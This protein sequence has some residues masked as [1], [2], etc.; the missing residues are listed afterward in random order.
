M[1]EKLLSKIENPWHRC[2]EIKQKRHD[3][4]LRVC[5][6]IK[7]SRVHRLGNSIVFR[8]VFLRVVSRTDI[9]FDAG[10]SFSVDFIQLTSLC[11]VIAFEK[12]F[13]LRKQ[14]GAESVDS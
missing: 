7:S 14:S 9:V 4:S 6:F 12:L 13:S 10:M 5:F 3:C 11:A 8:E 1:N 2:G